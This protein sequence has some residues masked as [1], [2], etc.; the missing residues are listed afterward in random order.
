MDDDRKDAANTALVTALRDKSKN[1]KIEIA[2]EMV[3]SGH[4]H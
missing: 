3:R 2:R 4:G 1:V